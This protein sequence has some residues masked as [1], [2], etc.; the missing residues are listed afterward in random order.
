M[1]MFH[2]TPQPAQTPFIP[3]WSP[4]EPVPSQAMPPTYPTVPSSS[5]SSS[6]SSATSAVGS[7]LP[8]SQLLFVALPPVGQVYLPA[9]P[10]PFQYPAPPVRQSYPPVGQPPV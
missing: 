1:C 10:P 3:P 7:P 2:L 8:S 4:T 6:S 9:R 5:K